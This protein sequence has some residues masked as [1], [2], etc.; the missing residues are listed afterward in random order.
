MASSRRTGTNEQIS[1]YGDVTRDYQVGELSVWEAFTDV[2]LVTIV[3]SFVL[4]CYDDAASFDDYVNLDGATTNSSYFRIIR[5]ASGEEHD[6]TPNNGF[7]FN[8][9]TDAHTI[10]VS[11]NYSSIQDLIIISTIN[12]A[13]LRYGLVLNG[14][15]NLGVGCLIKSNN[16]GT[17]INRGITLNNG[18][19]QT[20]TVLINCLAYE[21]E[22]IGIA[23]I[24]NTGQTNTAYNCISCDNSDDGFYMYG[25]SA[26]TVKLTNCLSYNNN[27]K[28]FNSNGTP[29]ETITYCAS[30]DATA[31]D[32]GGAGNRI[33]QAFTFID[34]GTDDYHL[35]SNDTGARNFGTDLSADGTFAFNDDIDSEIRPGETAWDIGFDEWKAAY[36]I[37][38]S[39][40]SYILTGQS[41]NTLRGFKIVTGSGTYILTGQD[42]DLIAKCKIS[43]SGGTYIITGQDVDLIIGR[44]IIVESGTY[45]I[46]G[47]DID[48]IRTC[49]IIPETGTFIITGQDIT[50]THTTYYGILKIWNSSLSVWM[51]VG[52]EG[53]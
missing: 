8:N 31:D 51:K 19:T 4:E 52:A 34:I 38:L 41:T 43:A 23:I 50:L 26:G 11:E 25:V 10:K 53:L 12:S 15:Y 14:A 37:T 40:G 2:D 29:I 21:C 28:D 33:N 30:A 35:A 24:A 48:I 17:G 45:I 39:G 13:T 7:T 22:G 36:I 32:W 20:G 47:Q 27:G 18:G 1:T 44:I 46:T 49:K 5:P 42:V 3:T 9:T 6:G 16:S